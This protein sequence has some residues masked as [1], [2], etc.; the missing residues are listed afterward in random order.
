MGIFEVVE[1]Y[2]ALDTRVLA[3]MVSCP[4][5]KVWTAYIGEVDG[6]SHQREFHAVALFGTRLDEAIAKAIFP[7]HPDFVY[8]TRDLGRV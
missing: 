1:S 7:N 4:S 2:I 8:E 6:Q 3:V 5:Q